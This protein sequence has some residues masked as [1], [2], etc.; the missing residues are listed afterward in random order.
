[1]NTG[2]NLKMIDELTAGKLGVHDTPC[3]LCSPTRK[4]ANRRKRVLRIWHLDPGFAGYYCAH[5]LELG[6]TSDGV[7][8]HLDPAKLAKARAEARQF[9]AKAAAARRGIAQWLW[10]RRLS[11][12]GSPV[13][14]YLREVRAYRG[15]FPP[16]LGFLP[17]R[18]GYAPAMIAAFG[19]P[20]EPQPG[21]LGVPCGINAVHLTKLRADG[22][23]KAD[24]EE[25]KIIIASPAGRPIVL[26]SPNDLLGLAITEG[27]EDGL[28]AHQAIGL[29]TW[30]AGSASIMP[31][32]AAT[33]P[34]Y[35]ETVTIFAH[36]DKNG[37]DGAHKL[38]LALSRRGIE[39]RLEGITP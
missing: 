5:C 31:A 29:G 9:A 3:P 35:I 26:A 34:D 19:M 20:A 17:A 16:T 18:G 7:A 13:E 2:L 38:A 37:E 15:P 21:V 12:V 14:R 1:M 39:I 6:Y 11:I 4:P 33:I 24:V 36:S 27:I 22:S 10:S 23:D 32:L 30:V 25:P 28:T 8:G